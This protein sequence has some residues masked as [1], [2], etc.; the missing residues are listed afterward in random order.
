VTSPTTVTGNYEIQYQVT[1]SQTGVGSD[2]TGT[3][4]TVDSNA[5]T[6]SQLPVS[7][8]LDNSSSHSFSFG[9]PLAVNT[10]EQYNW[11]S[12]SGLTALQ[13]GSLYVT[14]SGSVT[15]NYAV[16]SIYQHDVAIVNV[17]SVKTIIDR[18]YC[19]NFTVTAQNLGNFTEDFIIT[20]YGNTT[21]IRSLE[22][23]LTSG[24][25]A[26]QVFMWNTTD[27]AY[28]SYNITAYAALPSDTNVTNNNFTGGWVVVA[29]VG[30]LT[31]GTPNALDFVPDGKVDIVDVAIVAKYF[32]KKVPPAPGN[33][34]VSGTT[35]GVGDG[36]ID[37]T[38]VATVARCYGKHYP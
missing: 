3:V 19:G 30:D 35:I 20:V 14:G 29:G 13:T 33:C 31:G 18:G 36:K 37:I 27:F 23:N 22:F 15:G 8:W 2:F 32:G 4:V 25:T 21:A 5:Y 16:A 34:D 1:F 11:T 12:T 7:F 17:T 38:D 6:V 24:S 10:S 9:S 28:G 26:T